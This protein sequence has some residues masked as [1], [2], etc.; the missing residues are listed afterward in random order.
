MAATGTGTARGLVPGEAFLDE[1]EEIRQDVLDGNP[2][3]DHRPVGDKAAVAA[4]RRRA[5]R[6]G[7]DATNTERERYLKCPVPEVRRKQLRKTIDEAG[8]DI[9]GGKWPAHTKLDHWASHEFGITDQE[10]QQLAKEDPSP[11]RIVLNGW[12]EHLLRN[13]AWP[14]GIGAGLVSE[15]EKLIP[16]SR[17]QRLKQMDE[18]RDA[19]TAMGI[20]NVDRVMMR[21]VLHADVDLDHATFDAE[22]IRDFCDTPELQEEMRKAF[23]LRIQQIQ[24]RRL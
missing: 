24:S 6:G 16:S 11:E 12:W 10:I 2:L 23:I 5:H 18:A 9:F 22:V 15:G 19:Y 20:E 7:G 14:L 8:E 21:D 17:E 1:L 13:E 3:R 4:A